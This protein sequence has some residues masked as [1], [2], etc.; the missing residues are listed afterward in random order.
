LRLGASE[1]VENRRQHQAWEREALDLVRS[2]WGGGG[3]G[4]LPGAR[5]G[6][7]CR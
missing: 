4:R 3:G 6:G 1:L 5:A 2:G 7:G